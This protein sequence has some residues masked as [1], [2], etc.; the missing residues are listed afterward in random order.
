[1][2]IDTGLGRTKVAGHGSLRAVGSPSLLVVASWNVLP[3][4]RQQLEIG[5]ARAPGQYVPQLD[6]RAFEAV[7]A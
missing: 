5:T 2:R 1:M 7:V 6:S 4:A 3:F